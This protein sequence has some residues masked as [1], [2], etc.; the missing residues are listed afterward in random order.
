MAVLNAVVI[1]IYNRVGRGCFC[2]VPLY[3][4]LA[5]LCFSLARVMPGCL[6]R[7][8]GIC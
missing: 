5:V 8:V 1:I 4:L 3:P 2:C 7:R 6:V